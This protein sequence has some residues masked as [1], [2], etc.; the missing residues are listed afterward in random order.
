MSNSED[1]NK[2]KLLP[3]IHSIAFCKIA[4]NIQDKLSASPLIP[5]E[6]IVQLDTDLVR[7]W[8]ELPSMLSKDAEDSIPSFL[9]VPRQVMKWRYH[10][11]R[12]ILH[13]PY[14]LSAALRKVPFSELTAEEKLAVSKCRVVAAKTIEDITYECKEDLISGWNGVVSSHC[15]RAYV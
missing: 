1:P 9:R 7:W 13:R 4:T 3:L 12:I 6:D 15:E 8:D 5:S 2:L 10:N 11:L 14:L